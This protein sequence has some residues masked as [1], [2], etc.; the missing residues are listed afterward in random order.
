MHV[1]RV[2]FYLSILAYGFL[3]PLWEYWSDLSGRREILQSECQAYRGDNQAF[4][5]L[6]FLLERGMASDFIFQWSDVGF[7]WKLG[8][9]FILEPIY[10]FWSKIHSTWTKRRLLMRE[11]NEWKEREA[12]NH[13]SFQSEKVSERVTFF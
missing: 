3:F 5:D 12:K 4:L 1:T 9:V 8:I 13:L 7:H 10:L 11:R 2:L 6:C